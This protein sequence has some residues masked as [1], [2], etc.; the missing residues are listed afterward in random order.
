MLAGG[1]LLHQFVQTPNPR[2]LVAGLAVILALLATFRAAGADVRWEGEQAMR[3]DQ[4]LP[5]SYLIP[6]LSLGL[7]LLGLGVAAFLVLE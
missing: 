4:P 1:V 3:H 7:A 5:R 6:G 2:W